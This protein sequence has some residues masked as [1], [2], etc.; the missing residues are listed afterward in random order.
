MDTTV[1][2]KT[3]FRLS[4]QLSVKE[5]QIVVKDVMS[6]KNG[7]VSLLAFDNAQLLARHSVNADVFVTVIEGSVEFEIDDQRQ[8]LVKGDSMLVP[9]KVEHSVTALEP[10]K[11][12][13]V[14]IKA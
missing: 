11:V 1:E 7:S 3:P 2:I 8:R 6:N 4:D 12:L 9:A 13:L 14:R 5:N 10:A